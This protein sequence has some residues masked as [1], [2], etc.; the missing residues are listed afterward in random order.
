MDPGFFAFSGGIL[1][2]FS[3]GFTVLL[4]LTPGKERTVK[5]ALLNLL[6][7]ALSLTAIAVELGVAAQHGSSTE[8]VIVVLFT[9]FNVLFAIWFW[10][11]LS[12][13]LARVQSPAVARAL[14]AFATLVATTAGILLG[15]LALIMAWV[16]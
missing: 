12:R 5:I 7:L 8:V 1:L 6:T 13:S 9:S 11:D 15:L 14:M 3:A 10:H 16:L 4:L 2:A